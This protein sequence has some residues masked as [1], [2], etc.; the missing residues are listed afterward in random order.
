MFIK[1]VHIVF[2]SRETHRITNPLL[3]HPPNTMYYFTAIIR[4]TGQKD[5]NLEYLEKNL[6]LLK[7]NLP[8]LE[9]IQ[10]EVDYTDY[11]EVMQELSKIIKKEREENQN[12]KIYIN[13]GSGSKVTAI[14]SVEASELW[15]CDIYYVYSTKYDPMGEGPEHKGEMI[16]KEP[17]TFPIKKPKKIYVDILRLI[18]RMITE[19]YKD[20]QYDDSRQKYI[21]KKNLVESLYTE[22]ILT[23]KSKNKDERKLQASKYMKS[24]KYLNRLNSELNYINVSKD[25]RNKKIFITDTG[26]EILNIFKY[27]F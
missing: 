10:K 16:I 27:Y 12:C 22:N 11:I 3:N 26:K 5:E 23:L 19:R 21:F 4:E 24:K 7:E 8:Q 14:A 18:E 6:S 17:L 1:Q 13:V 2:N 20:K 9:I 15:N 25:K